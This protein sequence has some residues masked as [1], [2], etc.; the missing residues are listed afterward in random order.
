MLSTPTTESPRG[1]TQL[2]A[3]ATARRITRPQLSIVPRRSC[4]SRLIS[5]LSA[6]ILSRQIEDQHC[7]MTPSRKVQKPVNCPEPTHPEH[8]PCECDVCIHAPPKQKSNP[9]V[10]TRRPEHETPSDVR[11]RRTHACM[12]ISR[13]DRNHLRCARSI[14]TKA[15]P[16]EG[17]FGLPSICPRH[18]QDHVRPPSDNNQKYPP[19]TVC[20]ENEHAPVCHN[21]WRNMSQHHLQLQH[22]TE[23][24]NN[25]R[26]H[27]TTPCG[28]RLP[29]TNAKI[30]CF[31]NSHNPKRNCR[32]LR[33]VQQYDDTTNQNLNHNVCQNPYN[34]VTATPMRYGWSRGMTQS[35][36]LPRL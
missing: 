26:E 25:C 12:K 5:P 17:L 23:H 3:V 20:W 29:V 30:R 31:Q 35:R 9:V 22:W 33:P 2:T 18:L 34:P 21:R 7:A 16:V 13:H 24:D 4:L 27:P 1:M 6:W 10:E 28:L 36:Q 11:K 15:A 8:V 32:Q 14:Q 19:I